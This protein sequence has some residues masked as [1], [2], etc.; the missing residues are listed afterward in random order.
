MVKDAKNSNE[1]P[2]DIEY[3][4]LKDLFMEGYDK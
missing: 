4:W 1:G 2:N 3:G